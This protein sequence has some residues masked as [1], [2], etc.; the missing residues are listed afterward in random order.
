VTNANITDRRAYAA[1]LGG[2][3]VCTSATRPAVGLYEGMPIYETDTD[4]LMVWT[5][6]AWL[7]PADPKPLC[8]VQRN[9]DQSIP[10]AETTTIE[11]DAELTDI[12]G[13][14]WAAG[15]P[16]RVTAVRT[17]W[18]R[19]T[20]HTSWEADA[21]G[22]RITSL[23]KNG[24]TTGVQANTF[25]SLAATF[26]PP[27]LVEDV[28]LTAGEYLEA[29]VR[30]SSGSALDLADVAGTSNRMSVMWERP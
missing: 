22:T 16:T 7:Y 21:A 24:A 12:P 9:A 25:P 30:Q 6:A 8:R 17:G 20:V 28:Y 3:V 10:N 2:I 4:S 13:G 19:V 14:M 23:L 18:H 11:W 26:S 27:P 1:A 29:Q 5:G 15:Q